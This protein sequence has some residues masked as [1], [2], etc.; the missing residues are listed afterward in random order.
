M[1]SASLVRALTV[2]SGVLTQASL[3]P[4][5]CDKSSSVPNPNAP[6]DGDGVSQATSRMPT[7]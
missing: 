3:P 7:S 5:P 6:C 4:P 2:P 1:A